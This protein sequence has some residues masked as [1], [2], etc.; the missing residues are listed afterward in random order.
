MAAF[1]DIQTAEQESVPGVSSDTPENAPSRTIRLREPPP[2]LPIEKTTRRSLAANL[3]A[4]LFSRRVRVSRNYTSTTTTRHCARSTIHGTIQTSVEAV[5][6]SGAGW[7]ASTEASTT[8]KA[9]H[10]FSDHDYIVVGMWEDDGQRV[11]KEV[12]LPVP[13]S[14]PE[15]PSHGQLFKQIRK[16]EQNLRPWFKRVLSLKR[17]AGFGVYRCVP[18]DG[19]HIMDPVDNH[20]QRILN[21]LYR[22]YSSARRD[23]SAHG[24]DERWLT[25]VRQ[26]LNAG[27][28][29]P[30]AGEYALR[31]VLRWS[32][33]K[34]VFWVVSPVVLS[35]VIAFWYMYK[36]RG[37][38]A[39][40]VAVVQT[41]W[42]IASYIITAAAL[43]VAGLGT[44]TQLGE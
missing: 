23:S 34:I 36:P 32:A 2:P 39:D 42:T 35:L 26:E 4:G 24:L 11:P 19:Y 10:G 25:W 17:V 18:S 12:I 37:P 1:Q 3:E 27:V 41:A 14:P 15:H 6:P 21:D 33:A 31:L 38:E 40:E 7:E 44:V 43:V 22:D 28:K 13:P 30:D 9:N 29:D 5:L 16:A 8:K 20:T